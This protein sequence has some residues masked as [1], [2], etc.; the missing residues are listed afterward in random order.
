VLYETR[1]VATV[2]ILSFDTAVE[3]LRTRCKAKLDQCGLREEHYSGIASDRNEPCAFCEV[4]S[5]TPALLAQARNKVKRLRK[6]Y[7]PGKTVWLDAKK[8]RT[9]QA[10]R[11]ADKQVVSKNPKFKYVKVGNKVMG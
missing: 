7:I 8:I 2:G 5:K 4:V 11:G 6:Q 1:T 9:E 10:E 3:E